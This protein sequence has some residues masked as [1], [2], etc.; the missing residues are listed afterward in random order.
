MSEW[1]LGRGDG[2]ECCPVG[3]SAGPARAGGTGERAVSLL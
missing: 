3:E 1:L 2:A